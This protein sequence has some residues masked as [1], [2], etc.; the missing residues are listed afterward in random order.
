[1]RQNK[2]SYLNGKQ[3]MES[4]NEPRY[5]VRIFHPKGQYPKCTI[6]QPDALFYASEDIVFSVTLSK[7]WDQFNNDAP[8][9]EMDWLSPNELHF[10]GSIFLCEL[11]NGAKVRFY[12]I[13]HYAPKINRKKLDLTKNSTIEDIRNLVLSELHSPAR[14]YNAATLQ[15][16]IK[17]RYSLLNKEDVEINRQ[18]IFW[19]N[20]SINNYVLLRG[21][22]ALFKSDMLSCY[23]EFTEKAT[24]SCFIALDASLRLITGKLIEKGNANPTAKDAAIWLHEHFDK[25]LG[26]PPPVERYFEEFYNQRVMTIHPSS[27]FG[28]HLYA[29]LMVDDLFHLRSSLRS[30]FS[31]L[32]SGEHDQGFME[33]IKKYKR[34]NP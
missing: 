5:V 27:R 14:N 4:L 17:L 31:Y 13:P 24:I 26:F 16:C 30:I 23:Y 2:L 10:L 18:M 9:T 12:P 15:E 1:M 11:W 25:H 6:T 32:V 3:L 33:E 34:F 8:Y 22:S 29:P 19:E 20:M 7:R 28:D 21:I